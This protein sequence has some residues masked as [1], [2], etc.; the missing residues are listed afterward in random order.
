MSLLEILAVLVILSIVVGISTMGTFGLL[1]APAMSAALNEVSGAVSLARSEAVRARR[2]VYFALAPT[3]PPLDP[4]SHLSYAV[5]TLEDPQNDKFRYLSSWK[6]LPRGIVFDPSLP[7]E[8]TSAPGTFQI[9]Y[10]HADS[11]PRNVRGIAFLPD[12]TLDDTVH[13]APA[14]PR[15]TLRTG[16]RSG[17]DSPVYTGDDISNRVAVRRLTGR[18]EVERDE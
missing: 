12:G 10:P 4:R 7:K 2:T 14:W 15:L 11:P 1:R 13:P 8:F 3:E 6:A 9:P 5:V 16:A 18:V 17:T